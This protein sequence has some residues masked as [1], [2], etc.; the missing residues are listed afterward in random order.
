VVSGRGEGVG[1]KLNGEPGN[2]FTTY[3][4]VRQGGPLSP[5][6]FNMVVDALAAILNKA[7]EAGLIRRLK[8]DLVERGLTHLQLFSWRLKKS[9]RQI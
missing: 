3:K 1:I 2:F 8:P 6:L 5:L 4:G 7:K 9:M